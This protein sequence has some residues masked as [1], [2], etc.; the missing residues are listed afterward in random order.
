MQGVRV[1]VHG[2]VQGVGF[3]AWVVHEATELG[4][5]GRVWNRADGGVEAEAV[6]AAPALRSFVA[7]L[8]Q[9]PRPARVDDVSEQWFECRDAP[10]G[11]QVTG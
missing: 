3:R 4:V 11:F 1:V 10:R 7:A 6:G 9:G 5:A 2:R 8:R